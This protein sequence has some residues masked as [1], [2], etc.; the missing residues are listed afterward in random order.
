MGYINLLGIMIGV[1]ADQILVEAGLWDCDWMKGGLLIMKA[2]KSMVRYVDLMQQ[3][4]R[5]SRILFCS[6]EME[7]V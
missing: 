6:K 3:L 2:F 1:Q 4:E 7:G 5:R